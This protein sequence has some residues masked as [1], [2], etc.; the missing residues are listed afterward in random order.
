[1]PN[2]HECHRGDIAKHDPE[3]CPHLPH[4]HQSASDVCW[5][6]LGPIDGCCSRL[7]PNS[8]AKKEAPQKQIPPS[9]R[10]R[11]PK[12]GCKRDKTTNEYA[13]AASEV[14]VQRGRGPATN[15]AR[16]EVGS[17][18]DKA[19]H[20]FI[21]DIEFIEIVPGLWLERAVTIKSDILLSSVNSSL[22][23]TLN[24]S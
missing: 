16:A 9:V 5:G 18:V 7:S 1:M 24:D 19:L 2:V 13:S 20:P 10:S 8:E 15:D 11:H 4:H 21:R 6:A 22:V 23:H 14:L 12:G 17:P 3:G